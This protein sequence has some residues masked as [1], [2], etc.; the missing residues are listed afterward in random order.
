M[1]FSVI[2]GMKATFQ[3][4]CHI[5]F[6]LCIIFYLPCAVQ[7]VS[8]ENLH[9]RGG[10]REISESALPQPATP[11]RH[12]Q[13]SEMPLP[14]MIHNLLNAVYYIQIDFLYTATVR[15]YTTNGHIFPLNTVITSS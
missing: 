1:H 13:Q 6:N 15:S 5:L 10:P 4:S 14:G 2:A 3:N 7:L 8:L 12:A 9:H 11:T